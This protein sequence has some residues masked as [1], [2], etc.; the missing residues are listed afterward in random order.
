MGNDHA[1]SHHGCHVRTGEVVKIG[2][3]NNEGAAFAVPE[4]RT[5]GEV[6]IQFIN[7]NGGINEAI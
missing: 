2:Y 5:G 1:D 3:V 6:A 7:D 4:F